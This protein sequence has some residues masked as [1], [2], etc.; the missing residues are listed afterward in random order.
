MKFKLEATGYKCNSFPRLEILHNQTIVYAGLIEDT[1]V[2]ELDLNIQD[3]DLITLRGID[4]SAGENNVWDTRLDESNNIIEDKYLIIH[5]I[6]IDNNAMTAEWLKTLDIHFSD[7]VEKFTNTGFYSNASIHFNI[8]FPL[9][10]W[11]IEE[12]FVKTAQ[13]KNKSGYSGAD[14]FVYDTIKKKIDNIK[15]MLND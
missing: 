11:I 10:E 15:K 14:R 13:A 9:L 12:K 4:K 8:S 2:I 3:S 5:N 7:R 1:V 6:W